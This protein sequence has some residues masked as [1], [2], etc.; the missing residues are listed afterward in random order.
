[1]N[2]ASKIYK[3][4]YSIGCLL[5]DDISNREIN[6]IFTI[7]DTLT[8]T[9][10]QD[11]VQ[12]K[13]YCIERDKPNFLSKMY[14]MKQILHKGHIYIPVC[15]TLLQHITE[16]KFS[17]C[18]VLLDKF[19][20]AVSSLL[21]DFQV[22][23]LKE[24][25]DGN[26][27][28]RHSRLMIQLECCILENNRQQF[29]KV[30]DQL[31][32]S[33]VQGMGQYLFAIRDLVNQGDD[34]QALKLFQR[35]KQTLNQN[36]SCVPEAKPIILAVDDRSDIL[37]S[38]KSILSLKY[39]FY[40]VTS[41]DAALQFLEK[42]SPDLFILDIQMPGMDG[43]ELASRAQIKEKNK[44]L[45]FLTGNASRENVAKALRIGA[46]DL[47]VK[48]CDDKTVLAKVESILG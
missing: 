27:A 13:K 21:I 33:S 41:G 22:A 2:E 36:Y 47:L 35:L 40:G 29:Q 14:D 4:L 20:S 28:L 1:M 44:P 43:F 10:E 17:A 23:Q 30:M 7:L 6:G 11:I 38:L 37:N 9:I 32:K 34:E 46:E 8:D 42:I 39:Q 3:V 5:P 48:P 26:D 16:G 31:N 15:D 18:E 45:L 19:V 12:L 25:Q 24:D